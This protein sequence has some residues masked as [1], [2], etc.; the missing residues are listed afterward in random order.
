MT[1]QQDWL[2][3]LVMLGA[4]LTITIACLVAWCREQNR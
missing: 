2:P 1:R 3:F 4:A